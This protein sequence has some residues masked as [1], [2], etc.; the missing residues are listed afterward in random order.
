MS[1]SRADDAS[2]GAGKLVFYKHGDQ[3]ILHRILSS[4]ADM[5]LELPVSKTK[6]V[7]QPEMANLQEDGENFVD[8]SR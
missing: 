4:Y 2:T 8:L 1:S 5:N 7:Y 3:Y 6:K